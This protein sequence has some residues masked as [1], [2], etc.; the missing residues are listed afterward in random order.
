M[1]TLASVHS[2]Q[3]TI[4]L[5]L[6]PAQQSTDSHMGLNRH[7]A[8]GVLLD[9]SRVHLLLS[10]WQKPLHEVLQAV[11]G[12]KKASHALGKQ[13]CTWFVLTAHLM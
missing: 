10:P 12:S 8:A 4:T 11:A 6:W 13:S 2:S 3:A 5:E 7:D 1:P 9:H